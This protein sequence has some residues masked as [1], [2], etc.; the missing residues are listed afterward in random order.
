MKYIVIVLLLN[1]QPF[2]FASFNNCNDA[3]SYKVRL[4]D[5]NRKNK[6]LLKNRG[7]NV[8]Y[9]WSEYDQKVKIDSLKISTVK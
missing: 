9:K 6:G 1:G 8:P 2:E 4:F 3:K 7:F 5:Y